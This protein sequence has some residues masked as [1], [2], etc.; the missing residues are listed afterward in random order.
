MLRSRPSRAT[1]AFADG[2][3]VFFRGQ[4]LLDAAIEALV[5]EENHRVVIA[6]GG[7]D[8]PLGVV[9]GGRRHHFQ[10]GRA[11]EPHL[12]I[13]RVERAAV[14]AAAGGRAHHHG[15]GRAPAIAA[16]GGEID[17]LVEA[18]GDEIGEL[19]FGHRPQSH[20]ARA[21]GR[22]GDGRFGD[23]RIDHALLAEMLEKA[24]GHLERAAVHADVLAQQEHVGVALHL[25]PQPSRMASR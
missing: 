14:N 22:A 6:H 9:G 19:H 3:G 8:E 25:L 16:L 11:H 5:L 13:L 10:A 20:Q 7:L 1:F 17:D 12:G 21:D 4:V 18:A 15:H 24:G 23:G 2:H